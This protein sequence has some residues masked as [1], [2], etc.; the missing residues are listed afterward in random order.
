M[1]Y[2]T[3]PDIHVQDVKVAACGRWLEIFS[4]L[5]PELNDAV[6][7]L[8]RHVPC[9]VHGGTDGFRLFNDAAR[10]GGGIC[11]T[12]GSFAD[13]IALLQWLTRRSFQETLT[14]VHG[15]LNAATP[16]CVNAAQRPAIDRIDDA[17]LR[18]ILNDTWAESAALTKPASR[19]AVQYLE[20]RG[21]SRKLFAR[22]PDLRF[23]PRLLYREKARADRYLP[24]LL[25]LVRAAD[26]TPVTA[27]RTY[28]S[29]H[30]EKARVRS[31]RKLF[32]VPTD[33][34]AL[35]A[36]AVRLG[37]RRKVLGIA[38]GIETALS[39]Y[40]ASGAPC[41]SAINATL[42][43]RWRPP[44]G[45]DIVH[46]WADRDRNGR[47]LRAA[48]VLKARLWKLG[49]KALI[50]MPSGEIVGGAKSVDWNDVLRSGDVS[51]FPNRRRANQRVA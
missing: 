38:E 18:K 22:L 19:L 14:D 10:T 34:P 49:V 51:R 35:A 3:R 12:C 48:K 24:G 39:A 8:G 42:L 41:W 50:W 6:K 20:S 2:K 28:L 23:H 25:A 29:E 47:G 11:N 5:A 43:E 46:I 13:G 31:P 33:G 21:L 15:V 9:P 4:T 30:G 36:A 17:T 45:V 16:I 26:G 7:R 27:H 1:S 40:A 37:E 32:P 44:Q